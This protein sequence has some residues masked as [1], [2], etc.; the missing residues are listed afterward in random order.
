[1]AD[2]GW[3]LCIPGELKVRCITFSDRKAMW[4]MFRLTVISVD[5]ISVSNHFGF[6]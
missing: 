5:R 2:L 1:M 6:S 4:L 3:L